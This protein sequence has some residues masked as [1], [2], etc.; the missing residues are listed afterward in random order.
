M[1]AGELRHRVTLQEATET[2]DTT[3]AIVTVYVDRATVWGAVEPLTGREF[4]QAQAVNAE[5]TTRIR[6]RYW[7]G[8]VP[9]MRATWDGHTYDIQEVR[10]VES[11]RRELHLMCKELVV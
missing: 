4:F 9:K 8:I 10:E 5:T 2:R 1:K 7:Q 11:R 3:G 6:I